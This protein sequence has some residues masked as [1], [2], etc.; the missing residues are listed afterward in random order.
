MNSIDFFISVNTL[1]ADMKE[2]AQTATIGQVNGPE[3]NEQS[4]IMYKLVDR[5]SAADSVKLQMIPLP[6]GLDQATAT[7]I[8]DSLLNVIKGGKDFSALANELMPG[9][10]G[11]NIGWATEMA[12]ASAGGDLI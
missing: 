4:Y 5:T 6:Q 1:P 3:R 7:H 8:S 11:G 10:N 9:S 2:F 12:L